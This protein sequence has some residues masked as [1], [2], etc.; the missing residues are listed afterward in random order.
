MVSCSTTTAMEILS[1]TTKYSR[2]SLFR[3]N[4]IKTAET[5]TASMATTTTT[6][7]INFRSSMTWTHVQKSQSNNMSIRYI[8]YV[9]TAA[10]AITK[11]ATTEELKVYQGQ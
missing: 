3:K 11:T 2:C 4:T 7:N 6:D 8:K 9:C 1:A 5:A 10:T